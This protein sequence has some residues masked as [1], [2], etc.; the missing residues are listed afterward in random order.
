MGPKKQDRARKKQKLEPAEQTATQRAIDKLAALDLTLSS[1]PSTLASD[2]ISSLRPG[3]GLLGT[4]KEEEEYYVWYVNSI[5]NDQVSA[6][7]V[8][9]REIQR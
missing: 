7:Q 2:L 1:A 8:C 6:P 5:K 4:D 3:W 9:D